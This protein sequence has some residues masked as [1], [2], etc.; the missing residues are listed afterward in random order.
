VDGVAFGRQ[1]RVLQKPFAMDVQRRHTAPDSTGLE[2]R[3]TRLY[4]ETRDPGI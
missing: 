4:V 1:E 2:A 3:L